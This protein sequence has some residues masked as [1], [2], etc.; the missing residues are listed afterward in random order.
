MQRLVLLHDDRGDLMWTNSFCFRAA[1]LSACTVVQ[2]HEE[3][4]FMG[5]QR[6]AD[7]TLDGLDRHAPYKVQ[8]QEERAFMGLQKEAGMTL[9]G[10]NNHALYET[11]PAH[12]EHHKSLVGADM[13]LG[14]F[15]SRALYDCQP[16]PDH[17]GCRMGADMRL[18]FPQQSE[19]FK[20][21]S[22]IL[23]TM[24]SDEELT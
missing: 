16:N 15:N 4:A 5:F 2:V 11:V 21:A 14:V 8:V 6:E 23:T 18:T 1:G 7:L 19:R 22:P 12:P 20:I 13:T 9:D 17:H 10:F 3:A 24:G